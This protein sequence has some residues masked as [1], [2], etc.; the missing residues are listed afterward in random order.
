MDFG[1]ENNVTF[2]INITAGPAAADSPIRLDAHVQWLVCREVCIPG[3]AHLGLDLKVVPHGQ[4]SPLSGVMGEAIQSLPKP[5]PQGMKI[6]VLGGGTEFVITMVSGQ[7]QDEAEFY[8]LDADQIVNAAPQIVEATSD[9]LRLH[10]QVAP[11]LRNLPARLHGVLKIPGQDA[12]EV[13]SGVLPGKSPLPANTSSGD[14]G[15]LTVVGAIGFAFCGGLILNLMPCVFPV[16]FLK[17]LALVQSSREE[18]SRMRAH[19]M[20]YALGIVVSFWVIVAMLLVLRATG[21]QAGWGF[22]LQSPIFVAVM[23]SGLF[24]LSLSLAGQFDLGLSLTSAGGELAKK[25]GLTGSFFTGVLATLVATPCTAPLMG[26]AVGFALA[27]SPLVTF[28]IFTALALGLAIPYVLLTLQPAWVRW[29]PRPGAWMETMKQ[30]TAVPLFATA[31]WLVWVY[32]R[33]FSSDTGDGGDHIARLLCCFLVIAIAGW[34]LHKWPAQ[35]SSTVTAIC[36]TCLAL[37]IPLTAVKKNGVKWEAYSQAALD[38]ARATGHPVLIDFTAAW[39]LSCQVNEKLVLRAS[40]IESALTSRGFMTLRA[41]WTQYDP[42]ISRELRSLGRS[43]VPAYVLY[44]AN[45][46]AKADI[47]PELL[48]KSLVLAAIVRN[49]AESPTS[50]L[51]GRL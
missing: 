16:L 3:K 45:P 14:A 23:S 39:C 11:E 27:Q 1:Y 35:R 7:R 26:A 47:L 24:F 18:R 41:D 43:G 5:V 37:S 12:F 36:L 22:Q 31:I 19:G 32:G 9:G 2:P 13:D 17:G 4:T 44:P 8:P 21:S 34:T 28:A 29:L 42:E 38:H 33:L 50:T 30:V 10:V 49:S 40:D 6:S 48:T 25:E 15:T 46:V 51:G 20:M